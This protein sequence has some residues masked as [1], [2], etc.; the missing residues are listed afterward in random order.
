MNFG[1]GDEVHNPREHFGE[2]I[3]LLLPT[4]VHA[5]ESFT[6]I[7]V[8]I[9]S[10]SSLRPGQPQAAIP[11]VCVRIMEPFGDREPCCRRL[12]SIAVLVT[13]PLGDRRHHTGTVADYRACNTFWIHS[14]S[15][16]PELATFPTFVPRFNTVVVPCREGEIPL[17]I[18]PMFAASSANFL[19]KSR[20]SPRRFNVCF[21]S[22]QS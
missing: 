16:L 22:S 12:N 8:C 5:R 11:S 14:L 19:Y 13:F 2:Q 21:T 15:R 17:I 9:T 4:S 10:Q 7:G 18:W 6:I 1:P 20:P 3:L